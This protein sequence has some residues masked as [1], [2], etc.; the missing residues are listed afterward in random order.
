MTK[1]DSE[2]KTIGPEGNP[3]EVSGSFREWSSVERSALRNGKGGPAQGPVARSAVA[4]SQ[5]HEKL[6]KAR[7]V[8]GGGI[9]LVEREQK[10]AVQAVC[11][12]PHHQRR[13]TRL[14]LPVSSIALPLNTIIRTFDL[15][16]RALPEKI[17][18]E[19]VG[20]RFCRSGV[21]PSRRLIKAVTYA[22][23]CRGALR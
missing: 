9:E 10:V 17:I 4:L 21:S 3:A 2:G 13:Q 19:V 16:R 22:R 20:T 6:P 8:V 11:R 5:L 7:V 12:H 18:A 15:I 1:E 14:A 23:E